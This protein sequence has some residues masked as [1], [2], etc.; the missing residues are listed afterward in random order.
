MR[1]TEIGPL[2]INATTGIEVTALSH[3]HAGTGYDVWPFWRPRQLDLTLRITRPTRNEALGVVDQ[4]ATAIYSEEGKR[5]GNGSVRR[6]VVLE[7]ESRLGNVY[8][9]LA[10]ADMRL[11]SIEQTT[12]GIGA[13]VQ[14]RGMLL[15]PPVTGFGQSPT[16]QI[17]NMHAFT[18]TSASYTLGED[19]TLYAG[20]LTLTTPNTASIRDS[21]VVIESRASSTEVAQTRYIQPTSA[22]S[23]CVAETLPS[24]GTRYRVQS[25]SSATVTYSVAGNALPSVPL[26]IYAC[27]HVPTGVTGT[28]SVSWP[29]QP[30][31]VHALTDTRTWYPIAVNDWGPRS[32]TITLTVSNVAI[33]TYIFPLLAVPVDGAHLWYVQGATTY[34]NLQILLPER[35]PVGSFH[36]SNQ[37]NAAVYGP[38]FP[39]TRRW[40]SITHG[41]A[42]VVMSTATSNVTLEGRMTVPSAWM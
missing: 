20:S 7:C 10:H 24:G 38:A 6:G 9:W 26:M 19:G 11:L 32:H 39:I 31:I 33:N 29:S 35:S 37:R 3:D 36:V 17:T 28:M 12:T 1:I 27:V 21:V 40:L 25:G 22:S 14:V 41:L 42:L 2:A 23:N 18:V 16:I 30:S 13:R 15:H 4:L 34:N 5:D 8:T